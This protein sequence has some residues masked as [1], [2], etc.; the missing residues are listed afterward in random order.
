MSLARKF[1]FIGGTE[2]SGTT[3]LVR[4]LSA[5]HGCACL[6]GNYLKLPNL[7]LKPV[8]IPGM[9]DKVR[10]WTIDKPLGEGPDVKPLA[11][12][13]QAAN[14]RVWDRKLSFEEQEKGR[15]EWRATMDRILAAPAFAET[16]HY[17]FKRAFPW[18]PRDRFAPDLWDIIELWPDVRIVLIYRDPRA[19][20]YSSFRRG[21]DSD[22]RRLAVVC[23]EQLTWLAGQVRAI[24][25]ERVR[26]ISYAR[27]C[28]NPGAVLEPIAN[29][30][31]MPFDQV[32]E[33]IR[34]EEMDT[35][36]DNRWSR[37]LSPQ[38]SNWLNQFFHA[39]RLRQWDILEAG[40]NWSPV[41]NSEAETGQPNSGTDHSSQMTN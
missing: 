15:L 30:C 7:T 5:P 2:G 37:E 14:A 21:F 9:P 40:C 32:N 34:N 19:A 23:S 33:A 25:P 11:D 27:L 6:G 17:L 10:Y 22:L 12:A 35:N 41:R 28:A 3:L 4:L 29:F 26:I 16:S 13:F 20:T 38:N 8:S 31:C 39:G 36:A 1:V 24:G 18:G